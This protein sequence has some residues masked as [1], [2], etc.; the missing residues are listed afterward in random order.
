[1]RCIF[2][3]D[4]SP[5]ELRSIVEFLNGQMKDVEMLIVEARQYQKGS[6]R[7]VVPWVFGFTEEARVAKQ[8]SNAETVRASVVKG[9]DAFWASVENA[10]REKGEGW[11]SRLRELIASIAK[12][13]GCEL[14]WQVS[15]TVLLPFVLPRKIPILLGFRRDGSLELYLD[16]WLPLEGAELTKEQSEAR[17][18]FLAGVE[19]L[20]GVPASQSRDSMTY[21]VIAPKKW[22][23]R[24]DELRD[25]IKRIA[26]FSPVEH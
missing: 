1:M 22:L 9:E 4:D 13:P 12:I 19:S 26:A 20:F 5:L 14:T 11:V 21:R 2:F 18:A 7:I 24:A 10:L 17:E 15:C 16:R 3:L 8:K 25:L 23:P 6:S